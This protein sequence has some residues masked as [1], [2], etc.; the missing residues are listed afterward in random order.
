MPDLATIG[1][2]KRLISFAKSLAIVRW[3]WCRARQIS[4][5]DFDQI[6]SAGTVVV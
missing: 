1:I 3:S 2:R 4:Q 6:V 5:V